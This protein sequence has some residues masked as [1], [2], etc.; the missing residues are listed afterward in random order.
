MIFREVE[1]LK[2]LSH[3][4]I[5][6]IINCYTLAN[7]QLVVVMEYLAGGELLGLLKEKNRFDEPTARSIFTQIIEAVHH[8]HQ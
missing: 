6:K 2:S 8:C 1:T 4:N 3:P 7:M 5:V